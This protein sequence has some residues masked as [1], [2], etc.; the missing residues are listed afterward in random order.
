MPLS[1]H[2]F[3]AAETTTLGAKIIPV[4]LELESPGVILYNVHIE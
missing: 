1:W 4:H 2:N 3:G